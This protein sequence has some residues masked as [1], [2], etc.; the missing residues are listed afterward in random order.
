MTALPPAGQ[1]LVQKTLRGDYVTLGT[2]IKQTQYFLACNKD[3]WNKL[4]PEHQ[5]ILTNAAQAALEYNRVEVVK[6]DEEATKKL[7]ELGVTM[8]QITPEALAEIQE[9]VLPPILKAYK[10]D[11]GQEMYD[12]LMA[13]SE[14]LK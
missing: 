9:I 3:F 4:S 2:Q 12:R 6:S 11:V 8:V 1:Y 5:A 13:E 7:I 10:E 14:K